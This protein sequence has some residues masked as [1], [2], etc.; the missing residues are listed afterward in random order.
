MYVPND[1][2]QNYPSCRLDHW[3]KGIDTFS[4]EQPLK[5]QSL[6]LNFLSQQIRNIRYITFLYKCEIQSNVPDFPNLYMQYK[7]VLNGEYVFRFLL[8]YIKL[9]QG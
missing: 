5:I 1:D 8:L 3:L 6:Y 2:K 4:L 7:F 9:K